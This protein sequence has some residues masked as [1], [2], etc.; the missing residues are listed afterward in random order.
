MRIESGGDA[1]AI[2]SSGGSGPMQTMPGTWVEL[3]VRN[4]LGID[5]FDPREA[6]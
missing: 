3:S 4:E 1:R 2:S 5:P 6:L